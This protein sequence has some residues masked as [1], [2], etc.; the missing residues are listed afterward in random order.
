MARQFNLVMNMKPV[1]LLAPTTT[2]G[3]ATSRRFGMKGFH[4]AWIVAEFKQAVANATT[5]TIACY[6][7]VSG[8]TSG[9][10]P[11]VPNYQNGDTA[12]NDT[13]VVNADGTVI[14]LASTVKSMQAI[15]EVDPSRLPA[16]F[17]YIGVAT[18]DSTQ[19]TNFVS[20]TA[21]GLPR[22]QQQIPPTAVV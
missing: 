4:K 10:M 18:S 20:I 1:Q 2:N 14:T 8:G 7:L 9:T 15:F 17:P 22:Y 16:G 13:L 5:L 19:A 3:G 11:N 21:Y 6:S 12:L